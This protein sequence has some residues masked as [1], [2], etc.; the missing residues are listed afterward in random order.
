VDVLSEID[1][2]V[3]KELLLDNLKQQ[4]YTFQI[5][6]NLVAS[7]RYLSFISKSNHFQSQH[8]GAVM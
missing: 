2:M 7:S 5:S 8:A 1:A 4:S 6:V 3:S